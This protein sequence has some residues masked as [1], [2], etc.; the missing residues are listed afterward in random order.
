MVE[1]LY[2][3]EDSTAYSEFL[4][5]QCKACAHACELLGKRNPDVNPEH[6]DPDPGDAP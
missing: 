1:R 3:I 4:N 2:G 6:S 5:V